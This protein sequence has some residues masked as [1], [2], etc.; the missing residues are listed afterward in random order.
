MKKALCLI[1]L[2]LLLCGCETQR[3][4][5]SVLPTETEATEAADTEPMPLYVPGH[6]LEQ[7]APGAL[8]VY[9]LRRQAHGLLA[10]GNRLIALC[11]SDGTEL[12]LLTGED[13]T[14]SATVRLPFHL[15]AD[16]PSLQIGEDALSYFDPVRKET[17]VLSSTLKDVSR[18]AA[19]EGLVGRP[20]LSADRNTLYYCTPTSIRA[21]NLETGIRR[22]VKEL[23]YGV[24]ELAGLHQTGA[25]LQ[26]HIIT[27]GESRTLF[28]SSD[29]GRLLKEVSGEVTLTSQGNGYYAAVPDG[30]VSLQLF[31]Q[32]E[33][34][35]RQLTPA[36]IYADCYYLE[37]QQRILA[38]SRLESCVVDCYDLE[39]GMRSASLNIEGDYSF[40]S[41]AACEAD[42]VFLLLRDNNGDGIVCR[43][44][45]YAEV[46]R[47]GDTRSYAG[48]RYRAD[49]PDF[50][51]LAQCR[52]A[53]ARLGEK[54]GIQVL[55]WR[56]PLSVAPWDYEFEPE[57]LAPVLQRELSELDQRLSCYPPE[58]L[59][60]IKSHFSDLTICLVRGIRG[61][62]RSGSLEEATGVQFFRDSNAYIA[63]VTGALGERALY[64]ELY[65][66]MET[67][68]LT[69]STAFDRWEQINPPGFS[70][71]LDYT[72]NAGRQAA[73]YLQPDSRSFI[74][75]YSM[76]FP[77]ED[78]ARIME[79]AMCAG[80]EDLFRSSTMQ[81]K[82]R[83]LSQAIREAYGLEKAE[84][85]FRWEQYLK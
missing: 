85:V 28:L 33:E 43:W 62:A 18:I 39:T 81:A 22:C 66:V 13:M 24:Q 52:T 80:N 42:A 27:D 17:V 6:P 61:S 68:L 38:V 14:V 78:R 64:H 84:Q 41:A 37:N 7:S 31:G 29:T 5:D 71:D 51:A 46:S 36:D 15:D 4:P 70:Y 72:A 56:D 79:C 23:S 48:Q 75:T 19:P 9:P 40:V 12:T 83:C 60:G 34:D 49:S 45:L 10:M 63:I 59:E 2:C 30:A 57:Y 21:W 35:V 77:K 73:E 65:H 67:R 76:S 1:L 47:T 3:S 53:A 74:D 11:G 26:C 32:T 20:I 50:A 69:S 58:I 55:V 44:D 82:L 16:D 8:L 25:V 54:Y